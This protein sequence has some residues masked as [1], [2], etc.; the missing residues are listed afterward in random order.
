MKHFIATLITAIFCCVAFGQEPNCRLYVQY[1]NWTINYPVSDEALEIPQD[2]DESFIRLECER[3]LM[4]FN[5]T[6]HERAISVVIL[7]KDNKHLGIFYNTDFSTIS[8]EDRTE[9]ENILDK[10]VDPAYHDADDLVWINM[11]EEMKNILLQGNI[12]HITHD[13]LKI[14]YYGHIY[15]RLAKDSGLE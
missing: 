7:S 10:Y 14:E 8:E 1:P 9:I 6:A 13:I 5:K 4:E 12:Y 15:T 2:S 11:N 3:I